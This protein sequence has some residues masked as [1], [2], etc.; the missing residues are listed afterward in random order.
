MMMWDSLFETARLCPTIFR[1]YCGHEY[2]AA[3]IK[4]RAHCR[5]GQSGAQGRVP[6]ESDKTARRQQAN[7]CRPLLG[8][9]KKANVFFARRRNPQ[10]P[11]N[12]HMK[13]REPSRGVR[14]TARAQRNKVVMASNSADII[15]RARIETASG[16]RALSRDLFAISG[17]RRPTGVSL[18][19]AIYYLLRRGE[20]CAT[21]T[22]SMRWRSGIIMPVTRSPCGSPMTGSAPHTVK[23]GPDVVAGERPAGDRGPLMRGNPPKAPATGTLGRLHGWRRGFEFAKVR[24]GAQK[25]WEP[26]LVSSFPGCALFGRRP[27]MTVVESVRSALPDHVLC[28]DQPTAGNQQKQRWQC[29]AVGLR[30]PPPMIRKRGVESKGVA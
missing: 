24:A 23:L 5:P 22:A 6:E 26:T 14:R 19:T 15:A 25:G 11:R 10:S 9:E 21:G 29:F 4:F 2:T 7:R 13:G 3:N 16:G 18:S 27:G 17:R 1:L 30:K 28:R 20:A 8:E 12:L